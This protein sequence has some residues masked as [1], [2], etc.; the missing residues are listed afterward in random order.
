M[1]PPLFLQAHLDLAMAFCTLELRRSPGG[2]VAVRAVSGAVQLAVRTGELAGGHLGKRRPSADR[3]EQNSQDPLP[4]IP[5]HCKHLLLNVSLVPRQYL[6][7]AQAAPGS[8]IERERRHFR[9]APRSPPAMVT[10]VAHRAPAAPSVTRPE[11]CPGQEVTGSL[12]GMKLRLHACR[13]SK[14]EC[15]GYELPASILIANFVGHPRDRPDKSPAGPV[16]NTRIDEP[17]KFRH[18]RL[19]FRSLRR[20]FSQRSGKFSPSNRKIF[21]AIWLG[22]DP[23]ELTNASK[24]TTYRIFV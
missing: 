23:V 8:L 1:Q 12:P 24:P 6:P 19:F 10:S 5:C 17:K 15:G 16:F 3:R 20:L 9:T 11:L 7:G 21:P 13:R 14:R 18:R 22:S 4:H 2:V